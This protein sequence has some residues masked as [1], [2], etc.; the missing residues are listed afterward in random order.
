MARMPEVEHPWK[1]F[2]I[3]VICHNENLIDA[4]E[5]AWYYL[6]PPTHHLSLLP[7]H[8][9]NPYLLPTYNLLNTYLLAHLPPTY[10]PT[11]R[12]TYLLTLA[13]HLHTTCLLPSPHLPTT[14]LLPTSHLLTT[15][16]LTYHLPATYLLPTHCP[17]PLLIPTHTTTYCYLRL[18]PTTTYYYL[19]PPP[20]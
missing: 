18:P 8:L 9:L 2:F 19:P 1:P 4:R 16:P 11:H 14:H 13:H 5:S 17:P 3:F 20:Y 6:P 7:T 12:P 15:Y 10:L